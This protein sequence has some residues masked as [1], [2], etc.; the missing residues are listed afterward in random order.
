LITD[1]E[2]DMS[3][4]AAGFRRIGPGISIQRSRAHATAAFASE[5]HRDAPWRLSG[6]RLFVLVIPLALAAEGVARIVARLYD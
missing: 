5:A 2:K 4:R 6:I 3:E 1:R